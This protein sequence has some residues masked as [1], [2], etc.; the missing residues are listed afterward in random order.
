[1]G[2]KSKTPRSRTS[3]QLTDFTWISALYELGQ[4]A[5]NGAEPG[6]VQQAIL[7]HIVTGFG[8]TSGSIAL[9]VDGAEGLLEIV[10]GTDLPPG[11]VGS[12][13][14]RGIGVFGHVVATGEPILINGDVAE[15]GLPLRR[16][17]RGDR[18]SHSAMCWPLEVQGRI[19]GAVAVNRAPGSLRYR[20]DD[21]NRGQALTS[22]LALVIANHRMHVERDTRILEL[23]TLNASMQRI[24]TLLSEAQD[25]LI[26]SEKLASIGQLAAGVAHEINNP[27]GFVLS[28][29]G[30]LESYLGSLF[31]LVEIY[32]EEAGRLPA[33][34]ER[35]R[36]MRER[37]NF[38]FMR[39]DALAL[40]AESRDGLMR[41]KRIT[42]DVKGYSR[43][44]PDE[45]WEH[46]NLREALERALN[47]AHNEIK[48]KACIETHY[49]DV[50][51][52]EC[53][54]SRL[55]Q[56]FLNLI[57]NASQAI[58]GNGTIRISTGASADEAWVTIQD[59]GCGIAREN[60]KH[61][62]EPF[63]TT[64]P[65]G[66]GTG[67]GLSVSESIVRRHGGRIDVESELARG[68][69]FTVRLPLRQPRAESDLDEPVKD[70][71]L[72]KPETV[73]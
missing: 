64:K 36:E 10:A 48:Y 14:P 30:T 50:P 17:E 52:I 25:Q 15:T 41:V 34:S 13:P 27:I 38:D 22:L 19:I 2:A 4:A 3:G 37:I 5:A 32:A 66:K 16:N 61:I 54:P 33:S 28:N 49:G 21:L 69:S 63:Y 8:A 1:M 67:L 46:L 53:M 57:V 31:G 68:S 51:D 39:E 56:V 71:S 12:R 60:L 44:G 35:A 11:V 40:I 42:Q 62:F 29:I 59:T 9:C 70:L 72:G 26:Q 45:I 47:I 23:S 24:N 18:Q 43:G 7:E 20:V 55:Q 73:S 65:V 58:E 6:Q